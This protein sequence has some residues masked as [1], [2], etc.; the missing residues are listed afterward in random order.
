[1][2]A[3]PDSDAIE[4]PEAPKLVVGLRHKG[5]LYFCCS[6]PRACVCM[7][8]AVLID[9]FVMLG[10]TSVL[11]STGTN[12]AAFYFAALIFSS[13]CIL[14]YSPSRASAPKTQSSS[15]RLS[16]SARA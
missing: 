7:L 3:F 9:I 15:S 14:M 16:A 6:L 5:S 1:M 11:L 10:Y 12:T 2:A 4:L 13:A 8:I